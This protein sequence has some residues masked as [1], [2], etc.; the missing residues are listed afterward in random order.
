M[1]KDKLKVNLYDI[2][3][4]W[5]L[6]KF[7]RRMM[8]ELIKMGID[9]KISD[10]YDASADIN[11]YPLYSFVDYTNQKHPVDTFMITHVDSASKV[12]M[13]RKRLT[14][15][16]MGICMSKYTMDFLTSCGCPREK[17]CYVNPAHDHIIKP[18]KYVVGMTYRIN[19]D[20]RRRDELLIDIAANINKDMFRFVIM[21][22][23]W[24]VIVEK[25]EA[26]GIE[27]QYYNDFDYD[28]Y[29]KIVPEFDFYL[30]YGYD[31]GNMGTLDALAAGVETIV[32]PQ[33]FHLDAKNAITYPCEELDD[34]IQA[35]KE[36]ENRRKNRVDSVET[37]TW[38]AYTK[39][40]VEIWRY[41]LGYDSLAETFSNRGRYSDGI[42][43][44]LPKEIDD[45]PNIASEVENRH[46]KNAIK[47]IISEKL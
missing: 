9:A 8:D 35:F 42:F 29:T 38:E 46:Y 20:H 19:D 47:H 17:L 16:G 39:K 37:W 11:H 12:D 3:A 14:R 26:M 44:V 1:S 28:I 13:L 43:S 30:Y 32:T 45:N 33:G 40:H 41:L 18:R 22:S 15:Y 10:K 31:E 7:N 23:G 21:G 2:G 36:I 34:F 4:S 24:E 25:L 5:I 27:V 6:G